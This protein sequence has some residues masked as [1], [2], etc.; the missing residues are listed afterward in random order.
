MLQPRWMSLVA[1]FILL[2]L[3]ASVVTAQIFGCFGSRRSAARTPVLVAFQDKEP[4]KGPAA[5]PPD[6]FENAKKYMEAYNRH[7]VKALLDLFTEDCV[8][9]EADGDALNGRKELEADFKNEFADTPL[10]KISLDLQDIRLL[11]PEVAVE[12]GKATFF[13]DGKT[14]TRATRYEAIHV[15]VGALAGSAASAPS[16]PSR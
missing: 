13:P 15:K 6:I 11:G 1:A 3:G 16:S 4:K 10:S 8:I 12:L 2:T 5:A 9:V 7:D 14:P